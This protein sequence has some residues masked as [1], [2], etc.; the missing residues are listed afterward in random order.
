MHPLAAEWSI[1]GTPTL[2]PITLSPILAQPVSGASTVPGEYP[3]SDSSMQ[4]P[5]TPVL[6]QPNPDATMEHRERNSSPNAVTEQGDRSSATSIPTLQKILDAV[7]EQ[8]DQSSA[9]SILALQA[10]SDAAMEQ[11]DQSS[12]TSILALQAVSD[13]A[14][15]QEN[16]SSATS[17]PSL[18]QVSDTATH[19][20]QNSALQLGS[21]T[22]TQDDQSSASNTHSPIIAKPNSDAAPKF[23]FQVNT[24]RRN[25]SHIKNSTR[26]THT[27]APDPVAEKTRL[28]EQLDFTTRRILEGK[29]QRILELQSEVETYRAMMDKLSLRMEELERKTVAIDNQG[30]SMLTREDINMDRQLNTNNQ[31]LSQLLSLDQPVAFAGDINMHEQ[32]TNNTRTQSIF[33]PLDEDEEDFQKTPKIVRRKQAKR[34]LDEDEEDFG[35]DFEG[36]DPD[37]DDEECIDEQS[38]DE[39]DRK[40]QQF[41]RDSSRHSVVFNWEG[42]MGDSSRPSVPR[43]GFDREGDMGGSSRPSV[44]PLYDFK[45]PRGGA[46]PQLRMDPQASTAT[47]PVPNI[48]TSMLLAGITSEQVAAIANIVMGLQN[49]MAPKNTQSRK[50]NVS[51][52]IKEQK[53]RLEKTPRKRVL[54]VRAHFA[55]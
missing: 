8:E 27:D 18:R 10:V 28:V 11:E 22:A 29:D 52:T 12:A 24:K 1:S 36:F 2:K 20:D 32:L 42:D 4:K 37:E 34:T 26:N 30:S 23:Q 43:Q 44:P 5:S 48:P 7:M 35:L 39:D 46:G 31:L 15:D 17:I 51:G 47:N 9:T 14:M 41:L 53:S 54:V 16:Q 38:P 13:A 55:S 25:N 50:M 49:N 45:R 21:D 3:D 6:V 40:A 19:D 33:R